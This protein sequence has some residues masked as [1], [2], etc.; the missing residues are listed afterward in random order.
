MVGCILLYIRKCH[1]IV[2]YVDGNL[3]AFLNWSTI[4]KEFVIKILVIHAYGHLARA[5][6][7]KNA[8]SA[9]EQ[10]GVVYIQGGV[11]YIRETMD[12]LYRNS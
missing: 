4:K 1:Q 2:T 9:L 11:V 6:N 12:S 7:H 10:G 3:L 8:F 5:S